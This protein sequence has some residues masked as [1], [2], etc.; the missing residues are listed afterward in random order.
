MQD[1]KQRVAL[2]SIAAGGGLTLAKGVVG[3]TIDSLALPRPE[4]SATCEQNRASARSA[5]SG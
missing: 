5:N 3:L 1:N 2:T 4:H